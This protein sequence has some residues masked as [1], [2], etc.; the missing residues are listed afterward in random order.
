MSWPGPLAA[1]RTDTVTGSVLT[2][3]VT[4]EAVA[5]LTGRPKI[6]DV[7]RKHPLLAHAVAAA[8][9]L[10]VFLQVKEVVAEVV[11]AAQGEHDAPPD[12]LLRPGRAVSSREDHLTHIKRVGRICEQAE[13]FPP[14]LFQLDAMLDE[15]RQVPRTPRAAELADLLLDM[16]WELTA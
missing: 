9:L 3:L 10:H 11:T 7:C 6:T 1:N 5:Y 8:W 16:R 4:Y 14:T 12:Y 15:L 13:R 2:G